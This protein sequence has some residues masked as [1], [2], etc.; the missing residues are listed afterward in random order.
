MEARTERSSARL[1]RRLHSLC[2]AVLCIA[3]ASGCSDGYPGESAELV[4]PF[5]MSNEERLVALNA[6]G[7]ESHPERR[8]RFELSDDCHLRIAHKRSG[9]RKTAQ[10]IALQPAMSVRVVH[11]EADA[12]FDVRLYDSAIK[13]AALHATLLE[14]P[15]WTDATQAQ[16]LATLLVRDCPARR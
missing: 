2:I 5:D 4:S 3:I 13:D 12:S 6:L 10:S 9:A 14:A 1:P 11:D 16:L 7:K 15:R 8:W